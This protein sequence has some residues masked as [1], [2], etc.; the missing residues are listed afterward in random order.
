[1]PPSLAPY[2]KLIAAVFTSLVGVLTV[3]FGADAKIVL[4]VLALAPVVV[5]FA[6]KNTDV[7]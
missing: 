2:S 6:P 5:F 1:M 3:L 7:E 4:A